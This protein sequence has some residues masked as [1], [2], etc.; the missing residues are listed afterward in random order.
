VEKKREAARID[1]AALLEV[2]GCLACHTTDGTPKIGPTF[3]GVFGK[4]EIVIR[5]GKEREITV[6]EEFIRQTLLQPELDRVKGFPPIMPSQKGL[7]T[8]Q[9]IDA[10]IE[11]LKSLK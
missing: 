1:V 10:I 8:D 9:E 7:L 11:Y 2:K 4:K 3:K 5:D 6:D